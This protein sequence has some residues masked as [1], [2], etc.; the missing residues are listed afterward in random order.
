M[1]AAGVGGLGG[2]YGGNPVA[3]AAALAA[4][5]F[6]ERE[7]LPDRAEAIG[8]IVG[9]RFRGFAARFP[10]VGD[11]RGLGAMRALELVRDRSSREPDKKRTDATIRRAWESG[12]LLISAGTSGNVIRVLMPLV[13]TDEELSEG[14]DVLEHALGAA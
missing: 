2:T 4:I 8:R 12:L 5:D 6:L 3:C 1:D 9:E 11:A 13:T 10:F 14:L 7:R